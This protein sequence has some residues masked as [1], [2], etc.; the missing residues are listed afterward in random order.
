LAEAKNDPRFLQLDE[1]IEKYKK[2]RGSLIPVLHE[3]QGVFGYLPENVQIYIAEGLNVP[4]SEV[5]GVVSF[6]SLFST[7]PRGKYVINVC[8]GTACYVKGA[9]RIMDNL[10]KELEIEIGETTPDGLFTLKGCR[11]L[12]ACGLA[13]VLTVNDQVH[14]RLTEEDVP[15]LIRLYKLKE[16]QSINQ[17]V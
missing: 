12:G 14:G 9:G 5:Y 1:I 17:E 7:K 13:P 15:S 11:C 4:L 3:A 10:K 8:L 2:Q 16:E 6:Y